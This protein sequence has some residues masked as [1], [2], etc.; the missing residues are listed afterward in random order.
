MS[1]KKRIEAETGRV[2]AS[3]WDLQAL[4]QLFTKYRP[5]G[6]GLERLLLAQGPE[7]A[8][9]ER[10]RKVFAATASSC[11][12]D[13]PHFVV[14]HAMPVSPSERET[15][16]LEHLR[17]LMAFAEF[18]GNAGAHEVVAALSI[19]S[20]APTHATPDADIRTTLHRCLTD[21][22]VKFQEKD[23][24]L[25]LLKEALYSMANDYWLEAYMLAPILGLTERAS[26]A[27]D[28][29]FELWRRGLSLKFH[30]DGSVTVTP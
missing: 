12:P 8:V 27:L 20:R 26:G 13:D 4:A 29:Y 10:V 23:N 14:R 17:G 5:H 3:H 2:I 25:F 21:F 30:D 22:L 15:L 7:G 18:V 28:S 16:A 6:A 1:L 9:L 11:K 24:E 19:Q